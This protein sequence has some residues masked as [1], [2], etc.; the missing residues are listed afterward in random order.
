[1]HRVQLNKSIMMC[2]NPT[3]YSPKFHMIEAN[4]YCTPNYKPDPLNAGSIKKREVNVSHMR[5]CPHAIRVLEDWS[6]FK[7]KDIRQSQLS[8]RQNKRDQCFSALSANVDWA[9]PTPKT[10]TKHQSVMEN[11]PTELETV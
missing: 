7:I 5:I 1:M 8:N 4:N 3:K 10:P 11:Y 9:T 2:P 6:S